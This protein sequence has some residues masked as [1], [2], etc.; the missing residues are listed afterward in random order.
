MELIG[1]SIIHQ[2]PA[3]LDDY[4][5]AV[6]IDGEGN[7]W[8]G[9]AGGGL[10]KFD[11]VNWRVYNTSNSKLPNDYVTSIVIDE[12]GNKWIGTDGG[13]LVNYEKTN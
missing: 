12:V 6:A 8:I 2:I 3:Y 13:G 1:L 11:G 10:A 9:T 7:K 5:W 4:V